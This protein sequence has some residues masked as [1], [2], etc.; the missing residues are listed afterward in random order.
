MGTLVSEPRI[1][2]SLLRTFYIWIG[3]ISVPFLIFSMN[4]YQAFY[5]AYIDCLTLFFEH[6]VLSNTHRSRQ[7]V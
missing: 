1:S 3:R 5:S 2:A 4:K 6:F 7:A